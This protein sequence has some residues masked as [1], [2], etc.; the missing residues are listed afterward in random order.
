M[1]IISATLQSYLEKL[2]APESDLLKKINRET[3]L[4]VLMPRMLSGHYQGRALSLLSKL[5]KPQYILEIGTFTGY[6]TLCLAEGLAE[7]GELHTVDCN[8]ELEDRVR[9]YFNES[10]WAK[11]IFY[12]LAKAE[13][14]LS[15]WTKPIDLVFIDAD[16]KNN[17]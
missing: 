10:E 3:H 5:L 12:H 6:A 9:G 13:E 4:Q 14:F 8:L 16:K 2:S 7:G 17:A 1:D 15:G 11:Q